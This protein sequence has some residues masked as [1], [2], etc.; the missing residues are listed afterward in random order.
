MFSWD[1]WDWTRLEDL[2][3]VRP[4]GPAGFPMWMDRRHV[5]FLYALGMSGL[6]RRVLEIG[7]HCGS[8][9]SAWVQ[10]R[11]DGAD[12][13][14]FVADPICT[15]ELQ[16]VLGADRGQAFF[17]LGRGADALVCCPDLVLIDGNHAVGPVAEEFFECVRHGVTSLVMH[18]VCAGAIAGNEGPA[19]ARKILEESSRWHCVVDAQE[20]ACEW[21]ERGLLFATRAASTMAAMVPAWRRM[22][23]GPPRPL[24]FLEKSKKRKK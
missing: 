5:E 13:E 19:I 16:R 1:D 7:C 24:A 2:G 23:G 3:H 12:F 15:G 20:R 4:P 18:D 22:V 6:F 11:N 14:L 21:T 17:S 9:T 8:S 10:A